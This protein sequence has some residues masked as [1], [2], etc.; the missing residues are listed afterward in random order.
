VVRDLEQIGIRPEG[1]FEQSLLNRFFTITGQQK[2][3]PLAFNIQQKRPGIS[4]SGGQGGSRQRQ[5]SG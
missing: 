5:N 4:V 1:L 2:M 3:K